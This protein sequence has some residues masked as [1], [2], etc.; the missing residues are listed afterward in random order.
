MGSGE[1]RARGRGGGRN[2]TARAC[3]QRQPD[4]GAPRENIC[5]V[6]KSGD[7]G[8]PRR[9]WRPPRKTISVTYRAAFVRKA[10]MAQLGDV[11]DVRSRKATWMMV[12]VQT[13]RTAG[14]PKPTWRHIPRR[15]S[16][17]GRSSAGGAR[18][19]FNMATKTNGQ[20]GTGGRAW[21]EP[22]FMSNITAKPVRVTVT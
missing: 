13:F 6:G 1:G 9:A 18:R 7:A 17:Q 14:G 19:W 15:A 2:E 20:Y 8:R 4:P 21:A 3:R 5:A 22:R 11:A 12:I 10:P 16:G